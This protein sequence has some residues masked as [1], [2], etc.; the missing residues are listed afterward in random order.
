MVKLVEKI[1]IIW[2]FSFLVENLSSVF[3]VTFSETTVRRCSIKKFTEL[4]GKRL[5][6]SLFSNKVAGLNLV[7]NSQIGNLKG[8]IEFF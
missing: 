7:Q 8:L 4:T 6:Q 2:N 5:R 1:V 3:P